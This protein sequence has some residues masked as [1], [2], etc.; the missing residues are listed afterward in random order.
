M[1]HD[2]LCKGD[3]IEYAC[4]CPLIARVRADERRQFK[5]PTSLADSHPP[6]SRIPTRVGSWHLSGIRS[7]L[8][9]KRPTEECVLDGART[10]QERWSIP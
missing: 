6:D 9:G 7:I 8:T 2:P 5:L 1:A 4:M 3:E 10:D